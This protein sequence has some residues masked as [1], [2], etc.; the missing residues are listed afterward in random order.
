MKFSSP[1]KPIATKSSVWTIESDPAVAAA[2]TAIPTLSAE[3]EAIEA[4]LKKQS[5]KNDE[6]QLSHEQAAHTILRLRE[7]W[8]R[9]NATDEQ[10]SSA[11]QWE[12]KTRADAAEEATRLA[13]LDVIHGD[14]Q[15]NVIVSRSALNAARYAAVAERQ[16]AHEQAFLDGVINLVAASYQKMQSEGVA[17][18]DPNHRLNFVRKTI[19]HAGYRFNEAMLALYVSLSRPQENEAAD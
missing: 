10:L 11:S 1:T 7:A 9:G 18:D 14:A 2:K 4:R 16:K 6:A 5:L 8:A 15:S 3:L 12:T 19:G 17:E 13:A